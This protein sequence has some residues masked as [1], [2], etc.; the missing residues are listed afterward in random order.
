MKKK[1]LKGFVCKVDLDWDFLLHPIKM[2]PTL[3]G[4]LEEMPCVKDCGVYEVKITINKLAS[5]PTNWKSSEEKE[6]EE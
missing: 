6:G 3:E 2:F 1:T 5:D 4:I